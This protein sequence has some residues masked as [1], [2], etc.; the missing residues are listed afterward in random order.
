VGEEIVQ[1]WVIRTDLPDPVV[2]CLARLL[3]PEERERATA[4]ERAE[5]RGRFIASRGA[6]RMI[7]GRELG[8]RPEAVSWERGEHGKP[9]LGQPGPHVSISRSGGLAAVAMASTRRVGVDVQRVEPG[10]DVVRM[11]ERFYPAAEAR[12]V[13]RAAPAG[14]AARFLRLWARKEACVKVTGGL[15]LCGLRLGVRMSGDIVVSDPEGPLPGPYLVKDVRVPPGFHASV[16]VEGAAPFRLRTRS[17]PGR[18]AS[19]T[20]RA[21]FAAI[22]GN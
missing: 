5:L 8:V 15:L 11:A 20:E 2:A 18:P 17:W 3:D 19:A 12:F 9:R 4:F 22:L 14:Q 10:L 7:V 16:A 13:A 6:I 21:T 1:V